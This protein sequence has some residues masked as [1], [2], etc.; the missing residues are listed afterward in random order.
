MK[1]GEK[2][3]HD[4]TVIS[5]LAT[6]FFFVV[7]TE[8]FGIAY[9]LSEHR[10]IEQQVSVYSSGYLFVDLLEIQ[11]LLVRS[12]LIAAN[13]GG[14]QTVGVGG[15]TSLWI[16]IGFVFLMGFVIQLL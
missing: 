1:Y 6:T 14:R 4:C 3:T 2:E 15:P 9:P 11:G 5:S 8:Q 7:L 16:Q 12:Y 13:I 10:K